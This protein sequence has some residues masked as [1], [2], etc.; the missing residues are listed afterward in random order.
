MN[1]IRRSWLMIINRVRLRTESS[2]I[3][4]SIIPFPSSLLQ[5]HISPPALLS[6]FS[7]SPLPLT[8]NRWLSLYCINNFDIF[9]FWSF[10][11]FKFFFFLRHS[12]LLFL[13]RLDLHPHVKTFSSRPY[14]IL[15]KSQT[16]LRTV[17]LL[18]N[19]HCRG[20]KKKSPSVPL[21]VRF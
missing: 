5:T 2:S 7:P 12:S 15:L 20:R 1:I 13:L 18:A 6:M 11:V 17:K 8:F 4:V 3:H 19:D 10:S 9:D 16:W 14:F 21:S